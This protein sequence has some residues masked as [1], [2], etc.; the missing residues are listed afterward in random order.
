[1]TMIARF[2]ACLCCFAM[3]GVCQA[4]VNANAELSDRVESLL[5][6]GQ[7]AA[8][9]SMA[10]SLQKEDA[11]FAGGDPKI[12]TYF[13]GLGAMKEGGCG[14]SPQGTGTVPFAVKR[15][16]I[17]KWLSANPKSTAARTAMAM[18]WINDAWAARG[19]FYMSQTSPEQWHD[20]RD[21]LQTAS[22]YISRLDPKDDIFVLYELSLLAEVTRSPRDTIMASWGIAVREDPA[23]FP[24]YARQA[25]MLKQK[26]Y[27]GPGELV[28]FVHSLLDKPGG[29]IGQT[30]YA[31]IA[32]ALSDGIFDNDGF[33]AVGGDWPA[34]KRAYATKE[35]RYRLSEDDA[36]ALLQYAAVFHDQETATAALAHIRDYAD[37]GYSLDMNNLGWAY[38]NATG[39]PVQRDLAVSWYRKGAAQGNVISQYQLGWIFERTPGGGEEALKWYGLAGAQGYTTAVNNMGFMFEH[40]SGVAQDYRKAA[41]LYE[42]AAG[43]GDL[44]AEF[45]LGTLY[46]RGLGVAKDEDLALKWMTKAAEDGDHDARAWFRDRAKALAQPDNT[47]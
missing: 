12:Y 13:T 37:Q 22:G 3:P 7:F 18:L 16:S 1:M 9:D 25:R 26:W 40:G 5:Q 4:A 36:Y 32:T 11:R 43:K 29:D 14:C 2:L 8:L 24:F 42:D 19:H 46:D 17:E 30:A 44:R 28:H 15:Q 20:Y 35:K 41:S 10:R 38:L 27:G 45:H 6:S 23:W 31:E 33:E 39:V 21:R 34:L 47:L